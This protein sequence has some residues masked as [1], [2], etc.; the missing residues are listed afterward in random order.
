MK[1]ILDFM[2]KN[3]TL[4]LFIILGGFWCIVESFRGIASAVKTYKQRKTP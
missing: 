1:D 2:S 4:T 3:Q